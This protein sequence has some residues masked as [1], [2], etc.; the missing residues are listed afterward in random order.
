[1][2][3]FLLKHGDL[4]VHV[5]GFKILCWNPIEILTEVGEGRREMRKVQEMTEMKKA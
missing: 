5:S 4:L 3:V 2:Q 1:M